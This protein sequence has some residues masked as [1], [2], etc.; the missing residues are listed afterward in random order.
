MASIV[1]AI[2]AGLAGLLGRDRWVKF[3]RVPFISQPATAH[4]TTMWKTTPECRTSQQPAG[5]PPVRVRRRTHSRHKRDRDYS[6]GARV[7]E[8]LLINCVPHRK[9][10]VIIL[11]SAHASSE[12]RSLFRR[13]LV[14]KIL[15]RKQLVFHITQLPSWR[16]CTPYSCSRSSWWFIVPIYSLS[17][18][19]R[20]L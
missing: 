10:W 6:Q 9:V 11:E 8:G 19:W 1:P 7:L 20:I 18:Q 2:V 17:E 16:E 14:I 5:G 15:R 3:P 4:T 12:I 13:E